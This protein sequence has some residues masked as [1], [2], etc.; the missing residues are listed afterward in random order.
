MAESVAPVSSA[1]VDAQPSHTTSKDTVKVVFAGALPPPVTG[2]TAMTAAIVK[3]IQSK[4]SISVFNWSTGKP[5]RGWRWRWRWRRAAS[6]LLTF[7]RLPFVMRDNGAIFY[8][9]VSSGAGLYYDLALGALARALGYRLVLHHHVYTYLDRHDWRAALLDRLVGRSGAHV[10]HCELMREHFLAQYPTEARF[11]FVPP[12]VALQKL[13]PRE[14]TE[15]VAFTLGLLSN[16]SLDKGLADVI[17]VFERLAGDDRNV[18]LV[19]AGPCNGRQER[20]LVRDVTARWPK[21]VEYRGPV[22]GEDKNRFFAELDAFLLPT[23]SESWGIVLEEAISVGCPV[24]ANARG[25]V[26]WIVR[27]ECGVAVQPD[28][29][30]VSAATSRIADWM[31]RTA[32]YQAARA[33]ALSRSHELQAEAG[34][35][36]PTFIEDMLQLGSQ[37]AG[38]AV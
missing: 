11:L 7:V 34:R 14:P 23:R 2:M 17:A 5:I 20:E 4:T 8:Y 37:N 3:A 32:D 24:I 22:Y 16:L 27:G 30:F 33:A 9:P 21:A 10:V 15:H 38:P 29:D 31:E 12:S 36:L 28:D 35:A 19:L 1:E 6:A 13:A 25:C 18:R 26:P